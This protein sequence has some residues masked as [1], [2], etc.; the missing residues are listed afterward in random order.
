[1]ALHTTD[2]P[3]VAIQNRW[4][5]GAAFGVELSC[6]VTA[7]QV[8]GNSIRAVDRGDCGKVVGE[9][10]G[11]M[12]DSPQVLLASFYADCVPLLF[13]D[14]QKRV[15]ATAHAGWRGTVAQIG[16]AMISALVEHFGC[17]INTIQVGI[18]PSIGKCCYTVDQDVAMQFSD[19]VRVEKSDPGKY[20]LDLRQANLNQLRETGVLAE[21]V[22]VA[23][24]CTGCHGDFFSYRQEKTSGRMAAFISKC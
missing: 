15:V 14:P 17:S 10:D 4:R 2:T 22:F 23:T 12:T 3:D 24:V 19:E 8:H 1:M 11:L 5:L 20:S 9:F 21:N 16:P 18:G 6:W 7:N 13:V